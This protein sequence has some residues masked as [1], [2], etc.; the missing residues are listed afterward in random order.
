MTASSTSY[1]DLSNLYWF[2]IYLAQCHRVLLAL[3]GGVH[4]MPFSQAQPG[5]LWSWQQ[6]RPGP[7]QAQGRPGACPGSFAP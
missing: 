1:G 4:R 2:K 3:C 6:S 7:A 5:R